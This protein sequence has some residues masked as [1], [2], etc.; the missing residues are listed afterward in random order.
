MLSILEVRPQAEKEY[1][2][3][4]IWSIID[5]KGAFVTSVASPDIFRTRNCGL[6]GLPGC[7][8]WELEVPKGRW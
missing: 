8:S 3:T 5:S 7:L 1:E 2:Y 6:Q 4:Y